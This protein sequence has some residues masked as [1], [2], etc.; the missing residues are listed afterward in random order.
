MDK[1]GTPIEF[2]SV[3]LQGNGGSPFGTM[4]GP[5]GRFNLNNIPG[6]TYSLR[7]SFIGYR[8]FRQEISVPAETG[9]GGIEIILDEDHITLAETVITATTQEKRA[10]AEKTVINTGQSIASAT[11]SVL[12]VIK[13]SPA[14]RIDSDN[15][16][17]VRGNAN[18]LLLI[19]GVPTTVESLA[20]FPVS[21]A[22][23]IEIITSPGVQYDSEGTGG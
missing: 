15:I 21:S 17:S 6:G 14:V 13:Q 22:R 1:D 11:G 20:S 9:S 5:D 23:N 4:T 12:D 16:V 10:A 7:I 8:E 18:V 3:V 2:A 19:D